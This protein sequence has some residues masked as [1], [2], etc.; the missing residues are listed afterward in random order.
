[1][2]GF[3]KRLLLAIQHRDAKE[4]AQLGGVAA[5]SHWLTSSRP[6]EA[7]GT[8]RVE[9]D[10]PR[11]LGGIIREQFS[12]RTL[13]W[14]VGVS[15]VSLA[16]G[17][18]EY[19]VYRKHAY[20]ESCSII[21]AVVFTVVVGTVSEHQQA[22]SVHRLE[23]SLADV[24]VKV[25]RGGCKSI[26]RSSALLVG[27]QVWVETGDV[28]PADLL[29][30]AG[31]G[32]SCDESLV[33]G[34]AE[35]VAK[36]SEHPCLI[37]GTHVLSGSGLG[38]VVA[39]GACSVRG[40]LAQSARRRRQPTPLQ[41]RLG[42][43]VARLS[44][45]GA[46]LSVG[47]CLVQ[48]TKL[49]YGATQ[50]TWL[51]VLFEALSLATVAIPEGLPVAAGMS[52]VFASLH[53]Y[54][55]NALVRNISKCEIMNSATVICMDKTGT[56]TNN[57]MA[58][59]EVFY[60]GEL[61]GMAARHERWI[62]PDL[63]LGI[64]ANS[65]AFV[66]PERISGSK[67][68]VALLQALIDH[69]L[70]LEV[71]LGS[72][73]SIPFCSSRKYMGTHL[74]ADQ[75]SELTK[76]IADLLERAT[77]AEEVP[78]TTTAN[79]PVPVPTSKT[80]Y[81]GAPEVVLAHCS[82]MLTSEGVQ[83]I[84]SSVEQRLK[85][86]V[87]RHR[88]IA[89]AY[90]CG[91]VL[92]L[93]AAPDLVLIA[94]VGIEDSLRADT[95][96]YIAACR[97]AGI[98][99]KMVTGDGRDTAVCVAQEAGIV[100][101]ADTVMDAQAFRQTPDKELLGELDHLAV[102]YRAVPEDKLRLVQ[103]LKQKGEVVA[104]TGDGANDAPAL[105][106]SDLGYAMGSGTE[107][108]KKSSDIILLT[109]EFS[110]LVKS[111][112]W[113]RCV[114]DNIRKFTQFQLTLTLATV[115]VSLAD[116][117]LG[118]DF[119]G[120]SPGKLLWLNAIGDTLASL[121]LSSNQPTVET[122]TRPPERVTSQIVTTGM[123]QHIIVHC[124]AQLVTVAGCYLAGASPMFLFNYFIFLQLFGLVAAN[125]LTVSPGE[126]FR[127]LRSNRLLQGAVIFA[128]AMQ[129]LGT[130]LLPRLGQWPTALSA[131]KW[132]MSMFSASATVGLSAALA[133]AIRPK[134]LDSRTTS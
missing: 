22:Q 43:L 36:D 71:A 15:L 29:L 96:E 25:V 37:S 24:A 9:E 99:L 30:L 94:L 87:A 113:G 92:E 69:G 23:Q 14:L 112:A 80:F 79:A 103:L 64:V 114:S 6:A 115:A 108:A 11:S 125:S 131:G 117:L 107:I 20:L 18:Y 122:I 128:A 1:M 34:E 105:S 45:L 126:T 120:M 19:V 62:L 27:D 39:V 78:A 119:I 93:A 121:A 89:M 35:S 77:G 40:R 123:K 17:L 132:L 61:R 66:T 42:R 4:I 124:T 130:C 41:R 104:V 31:S 90:R 2:D 8:N 76:R 53:M 86:L 72:A 134:L 81:K 82:S 111:I 98:Q 68:E 47:I 48:W 60:G 12:D 67:T 95:A 101:A 88:C 49:Y 133:L 50:R 7:F 38:L 16:A 10:P 127:L 100:R 110:S 83:P 54:Q 129:L 84:G 56:L 97:S 28:V 118:I 13:R 3:Y 21:S 46:T 32:L 75:L 116:A 59:K 26:S 70:Y 85:E 74:S 65:T 58:V 91:P 102:L 106:C 57:L 73:R 52:L 44:V 109:D 55:N 33:T 63:I 51:G 5:I